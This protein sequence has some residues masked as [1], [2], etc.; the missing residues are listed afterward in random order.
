MRAA[1]RGAHGGDMSKVP[2]ARLV[3]GQRPGQG[4]GATAVGADAEGRP[5]RHSRHMV[6][7]TLR[8]ARVFV[9]SA[10]DVVVLGDMEG[11]PSRPDRP[12]RRPA[13]HGHRHGTGAGTGTGTGEE[14]APQG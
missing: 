14:R 3:P 7:N 4:R 5:H 6:G 2:H 1:R 13:G 12:G 11:R 8:V 10:F 9:S